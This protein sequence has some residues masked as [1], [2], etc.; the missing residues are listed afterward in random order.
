MDVIVGFYVL[1][2]ITTA[3]VAV[4]ELYYPVMDQVRAVGDYT[5]VGDNFK[6]MLI[7]FWLLSVLLAPFIFP[8]CIVPNLGARFKNSLYDSLSRM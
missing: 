5:L 3:T 4:Y 6:K 1:F 8:S 2:A 7:T